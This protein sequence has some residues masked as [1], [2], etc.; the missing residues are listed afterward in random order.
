MSFGDTPNYKYLSHS[1][2]K[3]RKIII[4][5]DVYEKGILRRPDE[6]N[7]ER[8]DDTESSEIG[9]VHWSY[10][11]ATGWVII[12]DRPLSD[13]DIQGA[14]LADGPVKTKKYK[15]PDNRNPRTQQGEAGGR[16]VSIPRNFFD[17]SDPGEDPKTEVVP[18]SV[19]FENGERRHFV[20][21]EEF[22]S[23]EPNEVKSCYVLKTEQLNTII[24]GDVPDE[25]PGGW[26][27]RFI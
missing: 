27:P 20:T 24:N 3:S 13:I 14:K 17:L 15:T 11:T 23:D 25:V 2:V 19:R 21:A 10:D 6:L 7:K 9:R 4:P 22:L 5:E 26:T 8:G 16:R 12:S 18:E 1:D